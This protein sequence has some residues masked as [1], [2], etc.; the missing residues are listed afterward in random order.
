MSNGTQQQFQPFLVPILYHE[1]YPSGLCKDWLS[2]SQYRAPTGS[3]LAHFLPIWCQAT[4]VAHYRLLA[5]A[6]NSN[7]STIKII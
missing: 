3:S 1:N 5:P 4:A 2:L 7:K 6:I